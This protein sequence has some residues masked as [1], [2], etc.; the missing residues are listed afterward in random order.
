MSVANSSWVVRAPP[1]TA[2][3]LRPSPSVLLPGVGVKLPRRTSLRTG[4]PGSL[5]CRCVGEGVSAAGGGGSGGDYPDWD[6]SRWS[7]HFSDTDQADSFSSLLKFQLEDAIENEDFFEAARLKAAI[8]EATSKD[9]VAEVMS[10][11]KSAIEEERYHDASRLC[12]L[13]G[14]GLIGWWVGWSK[15]SDNPF[16]RIVQISP[17]VGRYVA[18]SYNPRQLLTGSPG[19][20][21]FEIF[22]VRDDTGTYI[23]QVV[24]LQPVKG[25]S[26][27]SASPPSKTADNS[28]LSETSM[29]KNPSNED[30]V[31]NSKEES[32]EKSKEDA[33]EKNKEDAAEK[34]DKTTNTK[35]SGEEGLKSVINFLKERIPGFKVK[36]LKVDVP[37]DVKVD[38]ESLEQLVQEDDEETTPAKDVKDER[39]EANLDN[40]QQEAVPVGGGADS[41][42][43]SKNTAL[44]LYIGQ[45]IHN[46]ED[47]LSKSYVRCPAEIKNSEKDSFVLHIT[48]RRNDPD[49][50][51]RK[52]AKIKVAAI[53]AQAASDLMPSD[54][55]KAFWGAEEAPSKVTK[56]VREVFKLAVSQAQR[57][58][59]LSETT[60][61]NR[62]VTDNDGLDP[63]DGL[64]V[65]A[66]GPYGTEVVQLRR[67][68]G[69]WNSIDEA[70]SDIEFFEYVEAVKLTGDINVPAGQACNLSRENWQGDSSSKPRKVPRGA[71]CGCQL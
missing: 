23:S 39:D 69:H 59:R 62:I 55:A 24:F 4:A 11:L 22:L 12:D 25:N 6:W 9:I 15:D 68:Y 3:L 50:G 40:I 13:A 17:A 42:E 31:E 32:A 37:E 19:T 28:P 43:G 8:A 26:T 29:E 71:W 41:T 33:A 56:D 16:G 7:R 44:K 67:K 46:K 48:G 52:A 14:H 2:F 58:N 61:F 63:F 66:F 49:V 18:R 60:T 5:S 38:T 34:D 64:Y 65:G 36:M 54:I 51:E 53:A 10:E 70:D 20:P 45:V 21:F 1:P 47:V 27:L 35:D 30:A 57:R